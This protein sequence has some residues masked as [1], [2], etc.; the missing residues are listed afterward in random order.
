MESERYQCESENC[1]EKATFHLTWAEQYRA[2][3]EQ[4]F[5]SEHCRRVI[6]SYDSRSS[7]FRDEYT[8]SEREQRYDIE[9][10]VITE[11]SEHQAFYMRAI[12]GKHHFPIL[13]G[14]VEATCLVRN[15]HGQNSP[16]PLTHDSMVSAIK[17]LGGEITDVLIDDLKEKAYHAKLRLRQHNRTITVDMRPSDAFTLAVIARCPILVAS[18][19][20]A[21]AKSHFG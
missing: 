14:S 5:C 2:T 21:K 15:L 9:L 7:V 10:V 17:S 18:A 19:V 6:E 12:K 13:T 16:R 1:S 11:I 3:R 4:H 8:F 20:L